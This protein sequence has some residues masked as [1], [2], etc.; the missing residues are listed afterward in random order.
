VELT[1]EMI[2]ITNHV[3]A[4]AREDEAIPSDTP[5]RSP[6]NDAMTRGLALRTRKEHAQK[7]TRHLVPRAEALE[8]NV[9]EQA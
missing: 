8:I 7:D 9:V 6:V 3:L 4:P 1:I 2:A 5:R